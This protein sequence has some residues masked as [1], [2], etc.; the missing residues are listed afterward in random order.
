MN[1]SAT[2]K[3]FAILALF[4][5]ITCYAQQ[6]TIT[7][8]GEFPLIDAIF[9]NGAGSITPARACIREDTCQ[10]A[11]FVTDNRLKITSPGPLVIFDCRVK[12][13]LLDFKAMTLTIDN[14]EVSVINFFG[15]LK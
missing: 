8:E 3:N 1:G 12:L 11:R 9:C 10:I 2:L 15:F 13:Q 14:F 7:C 6:C 4:F 5:P